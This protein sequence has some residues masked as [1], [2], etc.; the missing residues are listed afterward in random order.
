MFFFVNDQSLLQEQK[1]VGKLM[2]KKGRT[3]GGKG[4]I[5]GGGRPVEFWYD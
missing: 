5:G 4:F 3:A 1:W 2:R